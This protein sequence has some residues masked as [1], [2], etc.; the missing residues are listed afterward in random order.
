MKH[1][2]VDYKTHKSYKIELKPPCR[3][4]NLVNTALQ[5]I[6]L[7]TEL[8]HWSVKLWQTAIH[9]EFTYLRICF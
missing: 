7:P 1:N 4:L 8:Q 9:N 2:E 3:D 5:Y 6:V